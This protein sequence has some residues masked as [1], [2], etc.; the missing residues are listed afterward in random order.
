MKPNSFL[1]FHYAR[2]IILAKVSNFFWLG[3][4]GANSGA[5]DWKLPNLFSQFRR[6]THTL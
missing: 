2:L 1:L 3:G 5:G 6:S 4:E